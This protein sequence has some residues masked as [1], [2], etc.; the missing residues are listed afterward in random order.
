MLAVEQPTRF[1]CFICG[2]P[3]GLDDLDK[4]CSGCDFPL[5]P[6]DFGLTSTR[7]SE[8]RAHVSDVLRRLFL[9]PPQ[10]GPFQ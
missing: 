2:F 10:S 1:T 6:A 5:S 7:L 8:M 3:L 4:T 9:A